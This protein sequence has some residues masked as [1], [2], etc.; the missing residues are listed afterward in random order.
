MVASVDY[1][2]NKLEVDDMASARKAYLMRPKE[3][4]WA[5]RIQTG[6]QSKLTDNG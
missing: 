4:R 2:I 3:A 1:F 6:R 5:L